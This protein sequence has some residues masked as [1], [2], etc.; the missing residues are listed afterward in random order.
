MSHFTSQAHPRRRRVRRA[1][2]A[3]LSMHTAH[4]GRHLEDG[5]GL[6]MVPLLIVVGMFVLVLMS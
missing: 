6:I 4:P 1:A 2:E 3:V 5:S